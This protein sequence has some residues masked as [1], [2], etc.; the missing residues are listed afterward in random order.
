MALPSPSPT[1][2]RAPWVGLKSY[3]QLERTVV[4]A[5]SEMGEVC[6]PGPRSQRLE[7]AKLGLACS[8][9]APPRLY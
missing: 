1:S 2:L 6:G 8:Q 5:V 7:V 9:D 4:W 3:R